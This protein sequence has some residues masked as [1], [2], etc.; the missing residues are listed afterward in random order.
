M[1]RSATLDALNIKTTGF[2][3]GNAV[4]GGRAEGK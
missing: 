1:E 2:S 3:D 4:G